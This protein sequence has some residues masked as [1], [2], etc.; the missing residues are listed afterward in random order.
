MEA[1][2]KGDSEALQSLIDNGAR[3]DATNKYGSTPLHLSAQN[4]HVDVSRLL[5]DKGARVDATN[6]YG[7]TPLHAARDHAKRNRAELKQLL[8]PEGAR[9]FIEETKAARFKET[10][11][12]AIRRSPALLPLA[13]DVAGLSTALDESPTLGVSEEELHAARSALERAREV[14][15]LAGDGVS[16]T[17]TFLIADKIR[18]STSSPGPLPRLQDLE[19]DHPDWLET[20]EL[21]LEKVCRGEYVEEYV[22][23]SHRWDT[24]EAPDPSGEQMSALRNFLL[25]ERPQARWV[26]YDY[27][28][29]P[30]GERT[31]EERHLFKMVLPNINLLYLGASVLVLMDRSYLS[32]FWCALALPT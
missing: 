1:A 26:F 13:V 29:L 11:I 31:A 7:T 27:S 14:Q 23:V 20:R 15:Q 16:C 21:S 12:N 18:H 25:E 24:P 10:A 2:E 22:A 8:T 32:R 19:R 17:F 3:V 6:K 9:R 28:S 4:G 30:Q 5:I